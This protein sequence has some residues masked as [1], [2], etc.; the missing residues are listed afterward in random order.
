MDIG[1]WLSDFGKPVAAADLESTA[2]SALVSFVERHAG[3]LATFVEA[4]RGEGRELVV[5]NFRT[6]RPQKS[7][8]PIKHVE[9]I[10]VR[11]A[12]ADSMPLVYMLRADFPDTAHQQL[13][14]EGGRSAGHLHR[15]SHLV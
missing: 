1:G 13:A 9:R 4:R 8:Y 5:L 10:G 2:A 6:G 12:A 7:A 11:F 14:I 3:H 15:R